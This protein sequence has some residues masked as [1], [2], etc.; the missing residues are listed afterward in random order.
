MLFRSS[1]ANTPG[2]SGVPSLVKFEYMDLSGQ[3]VSTSFVSVPAETHT[4]FFLTPASTPFQG[5]VRI[6]TVGAPISVGGIRTR[7]NE[8][9]DFLA[10]SVPV[11][12]E[13]SSSTSESIIPAVDL[14][15]GTVT[16]FVLYSSSPGADSNGR[17]Q[18]IRDD[19]TAVTLK[20]IP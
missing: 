18:I 12:A 20:Y 4:S 13:A 16:R 14:A 3:P 11:T 17:F 8:R 9:G 2:F 6:T 19:G 1:G 7:V 5:V 15:S 10:A